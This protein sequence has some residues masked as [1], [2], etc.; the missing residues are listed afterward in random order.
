M[1]WP[2]FACL[3]LVVVSCGK[4]E[5]ITLDL[6]LTCTPITYMDTLETVLLTNDRSDLG[7]KSSFMESVISGDRVYR[8]KLL[9]VNGH[10]YIDSVEK[11]EY[12]MFYVESRIHGSFQ[13]GYKRSIDFS[14]KEKDTVILDV[15]IEGGGYRTE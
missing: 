11:K 10:F 9:K 6:N 4:K 5:Y 12:W 15:C 2:F 7:G 13:Y 1:K 14:E 3:L 8:K